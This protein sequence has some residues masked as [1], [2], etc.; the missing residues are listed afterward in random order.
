MQQELFVTEDGSHSIR[1]PELN[2]CYHSKHGAIQESVHIF[3]DN[4]LKCLNK[5]NINILE[6]GFGTGLNALLTFIEAEKNDLQIVYDVVEL[7]PLDSVYVA[8]LNYLSVLKAPQLADAFSHMHACEW[9]VAAKISGQFALRKIRGDIRHVEL[10][11]KYDLVYFDAFD[12]AA[13]PELW[14][15]EVFRKIY[16][17]TKENGI[18]VT[19]S[20]KGIVRRAMTEAGFSV[21]KIE[22][23]KGKREIVRALKN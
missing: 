22:G 7:H 9:E 21:S 11:G 3:I 8:S 13:Q 5:R 6:V 16:H 23:P 19:F 10:A 2:V 17:A 12:P 4:G 15:A 20:S 14:T 18:L 1:L